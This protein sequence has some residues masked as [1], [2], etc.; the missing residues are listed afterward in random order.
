MK[1]AIKVLG[2]LMTLLIIVV[3]IP[4]FIPDDEYLPEVEQWLEYGKSH[5]EMPDEVN[6]FNAIVGFSVVA[7]KDMVVEGARLVAEVN[8]KLDADNKNKDGS[9]EFSNYWNN[10][11]LTGK[12]GLY[13][14]TTSA[15]N[16]GAVQW[17]LANHDDYTEL[18][19]SNRVLLERFRRLMK[20]EQFS[21]TMKL[22]VNAPFVSYS[23]FL[24][25]KRLNNLS[26]IDE[27]MTTNK[28][29]AIRKLKE[30][31]SLSKLMLAQS[32]F[33]LDKMIA[34]ECL[35]ID[36]KTYSEI[37]DQPP[38]EAVS[39]FEIAN[40][41]KEE[42]SMLNSAKGEFSFLSTTLYAEEINSFDG[43]STEPDAFESFLMK[44]YL[45]PRALENNA[46][47]NVWL[48]FLELEN[49]SFASR[50]EMVVEI[51]GG[52]TSWWQ[53]Y[54]D[55]LGYVLSAIAIPAYES[56]AARIDHVDATIALLNLKASIYSKNISSDN[57]GSYISSLDAAMNSA[58]TGA[59]F[60]WD[61]DKHE[62][63]F[64]VPN[65]QDEN[66]PVI[67]VNIKPKS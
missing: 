17:L 21:H 27:F 44:A 24:S 59:K 37:L 50:E 53:I 40:L 62:L 38:G 63:S 23:N 5:E 25:I 10:P 22:H 34:N 55:P 30:S 9:I 29:N 49:Y 61:E 20:M 33:L 56:Y 13:D 57:V 11:P 54:K 64:D 47:K 2:I 46:Y 65:Y 45:K 15:F 16:E 41:Q 32:V 3:A 42:R 18:V 26:I 6:R 48:P 58:Y 36:L 1:V 43:Y 66:I 35:K 60:I 14:Y 39:N 67:K 12:G 8:E 31:I 4:A 28:Q 7:D 51:Y 19:G 52:K